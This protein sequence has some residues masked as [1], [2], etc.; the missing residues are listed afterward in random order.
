MSI[1]CELGQQPPRDTVQNVFVCDI[2][3]AAREFMTRNTEPQYT[4][5]NALDLASK[6]A[7]DEVSGQ[8][9]LVPEVDACGAGF[10][11]KGGSYLNNHRK[12][13][14][15]SELKDEV[16]ETGKTFKMYLDYLGAQQP[17]L[18]VAENVLPAL[19][20]KRALSSSFVFVNRTWPLE[21]RN[22]TELVAAESANSHTVTPL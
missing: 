2:S 22:A 18:G 6:T 11:R 5:K 12:K 10:V 13:T 21:L 1:M 16:G 8:C 19:F 17:L 14:I 3:A 9:V 4:F 20:S 15:Q 7:R